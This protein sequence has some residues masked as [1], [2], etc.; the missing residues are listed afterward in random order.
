MDHDDSMA[1]QHPAIV[2]QQATYQVLLP[3][4]SALTLEA[5]AQ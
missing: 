1:L 4:D 3:V 2:M 5:I